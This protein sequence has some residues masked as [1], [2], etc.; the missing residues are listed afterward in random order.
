MS[1]VLKKALLILIGLSMFSL[2]AEEKNQDFTGFEAGAYGAVR[3]TVSDLN[4]HHIGDIGGGAEV[5]YELPLTLP[6]WMSA[7][8][9]SVRVEMNTPMETEKY[10]DSWVGF[11]FL[12][13]IWADFSVLPWLKIR[14]EVGFGSELSKVKAEKRGVDGTYSDAITRLACGF[15]FEPEFVRQNNLALTTNLN[16]SFM[17]EKDNSGHYFGLNFGVLYRI[18]KK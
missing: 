14:P 16:Y 15:I 17:P 12:G 8:G 9:V 6:E 11:N 1:Q 13:G 18:M 10:I 7:L 5:Y 4:Q 3:L 2:F